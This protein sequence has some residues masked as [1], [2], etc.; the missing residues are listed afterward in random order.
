[1]GRL[2][3][4]ASPALCGNANPRLIRHKLAYTTLCKGSDTERSRNRCSC[5]SA[6]RSAAVGRFRRRPP[7]FGQS[8]PFPRHTVCKRAGRHRE[9]Q[10]SSDG[11]VQAMLTAS[12]PAHGRPRRTQAS[13][14]PPGQP[15]RG[16]SPPGTAGPAPG[17]TGPVSTGLSQTG[18]GGTDR[19]A[20]GTAEPGPGGTG[21]GR[22]RAQ[23]DRGKPERARPPRPSAWQ[24]DAGQPAPDRS[25]RGPARPGPAGAG[26]ADTANRH[27]A[28]RHP[29]R[30][31]PDRPTRASRTGPPTRPTRRG[32]LFGRGRE[33]IRARA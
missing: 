7:T 25:A 14:R 4:V 27:R 10:V 23:P 6:G 15:N 28:R 8:D 26:L 22:H 9:T 16:H 20:P 11:N 12:S 31:T 30:S 32:P 17:D 24:P 1:M 5:G 19:S 33:P 13:P 18:P 2:G 3:K 29:D 21:T